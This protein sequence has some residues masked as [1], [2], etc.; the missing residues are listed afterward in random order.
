MLTF[1]LVDEDKSRRFERMGASL[2]H[3]YQNNNGIT[4]SES[5]NL[6][7]LLR[8]P[9]TL[10]PASSLKR[11]NSFQMRRDPSKLLSPSDAFLSV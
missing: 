7:Q 1:F 11:M 2:C 10:R 3:N 5:P 9:D 4:L 6:N 8:P